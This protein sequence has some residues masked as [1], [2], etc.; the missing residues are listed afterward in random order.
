M[1]IHA[2]V[3]MPNHYHL[4][5]E[6]GKPPTLSAALKHSALKGSKQREAMW[7]MCIQELPYFLITQFRICHKRS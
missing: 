5:L 7:Q 6:L 3:L 2:Y 4:I 1:K